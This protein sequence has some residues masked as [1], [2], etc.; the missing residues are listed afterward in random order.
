MRRVDFSASNNRL[1]FRQVP[2]QDPFTS[3]NQFPAQLPT[4]FGTGSSLDIVVQVTRP[5]VLYAVEKE[6]S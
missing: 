2:A 6:M 5:P 3:L 4:S 1:K